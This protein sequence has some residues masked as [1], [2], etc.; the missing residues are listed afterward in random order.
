MDLFDRRIQWDRRQFH[1]ALDCL[2][3]NLSASF[4]RQRLE[5]S[6]GNFQCGVV[7]FVTHE[8]FG[9]HETGL[10]PFLRIAVFL[11]INSAERE[12]LALVLFRRRS[13]RIKDVT[14]VENS[15]NDFINEFPVHDVNE[16]VLWSSRAKSREPAAIPI[17]EAAGFLDSA[18]LRSE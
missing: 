14:V 17:G 1:F 3:P 10:A 8:A 5:K 4:P 18:A 16:S 9:L 12:P 6:H 13:I 2:Q 15:V 11:R 7:R